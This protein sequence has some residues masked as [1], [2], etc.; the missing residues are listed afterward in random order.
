MRVACKK[1]GEKAK[2]L[3]LRVLRDKSMSCVGQEMTLK[4]K[5]LESWWKKYLKTLSKLEEI[6][7]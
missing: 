5:G 2:E 7:T 6:T 4:M 3:V 1:K